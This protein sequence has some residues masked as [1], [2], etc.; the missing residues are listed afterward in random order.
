MTTRLMDGLAE[1]VHRNHGTHV[2]QLDEKEESERAAELHASLPS[3]AEA[4]RKDYRDCGGPNS[5]CRI[6][7]KGCH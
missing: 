3:A 2:S 5:T 4:P 7:T 6:D 1:L